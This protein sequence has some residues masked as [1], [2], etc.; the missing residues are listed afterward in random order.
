MTFRIDCDDEERRIVLR[1]QGHL[2]GPEA[3][4]VLNAQIVRGIG[5]NR[6]VVLDIGAV[7]AIDSRCLAIIEAGLAERLTVE[8]GGEYFDALLGGRRRG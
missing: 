5:R 1:A 3:E 2:V 6:A 4:R 7:T 8:N